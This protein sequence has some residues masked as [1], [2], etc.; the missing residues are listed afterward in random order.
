MKFNERLKML[1]KEHN[2]TQVE[3]AEKLYVSRSLIARWEFGDVYPTIDNLNK[4][5]TYFDISINELLCEEEKTE[6][7]VHQANLEKKIKNGLRISMNSI[8]FIIS[9]FLLFIFFPLSHIWGYSHQIIVST[10]PLLKITITEQS[11]FTVLNDSF[12]SNEL[13]TSYVFI[14]II[15]I[16]SIVVSLSSLVV[17]CI[18]KKLNLNRILSLI[19]CSINVI[20]TLLIFLNFISKM[21][22]NIISGFFLFLSIILVIVNV[23]FIFYSK[24]KLLGEKNE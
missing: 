11:L 24:V 19:S 2:L 3:L 9:L 10:D 12:Y 6:I 13:K 15:E 8:N 21:P 22:L 20:L 5:S 17:S 7:I 23:I 16:V 18:I 14:I 1:R 4:I